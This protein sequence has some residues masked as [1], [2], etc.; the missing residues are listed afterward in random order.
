MIKA[1]AFDYGGVIETI[2][3]GLRSQIADYLK[4]DKKKWSEVYFSLNYLC[5]LGKNSYEELYALVARELGASD[6]Q[7]DY[8]HELMKKNRNTRALNE[9]LIEIIKDLKKKNYQI[10]LIS[11]NYIGLRQELIDYKIIDLFDSIVVSSEVGCQKPQ[12]EIFEILF[13]ELKVKS[14]E[15]IFVDDSMSSLVGAENIGYIPIL[16]KN[17]GQLKEELNKLNIKV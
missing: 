1:I 13:K 17:N 9:E 5:N 12:P 6:K 2:D 3:G 8:I 15:V 14:N 4:V 11:N 7:V 10:G 16:Y